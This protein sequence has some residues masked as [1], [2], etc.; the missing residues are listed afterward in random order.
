MYDLCMQTRERVTI[1]V[2]RSVLDVARR[3]VESGAATSI[4]AWLSDAA[5][6]KARRESL[7]SVLRDLLEEAGGPLSEEERACAIAALKG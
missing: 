3:D 2:P 4:S 1:S 7:L 5:E 6:D